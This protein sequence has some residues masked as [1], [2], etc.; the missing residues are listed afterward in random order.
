MVLYLADKIEP[1]RRY[2]PALETL[3]QLANEDLAAATLNSLRSTQAYVTR[4]RQT[5]HP[6]T[7]R[8]INWLERLV[9]N[10][11]EH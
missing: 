8:V 3:R 6:S 1:G 2:Y 11:K 5:L 9:D 10:R 7:Q 4:Q